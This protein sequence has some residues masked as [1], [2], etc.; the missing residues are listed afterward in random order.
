MLTYAPL[1]QGLEQRLPHGMPQPT[2]RYSHRPIADIRITT[3]QL[4][5]LMTQFHYEA[6]AKFNIDRIVTARVG[7]L[8][9]EEVSVPFEIREHEGQ[10]RVVDVSRRRDIALP[11]PPPPAPLTPP[12]AP[13]ATVPVVALVPPTPTG[14]KASNSA[15]V[16]GAHG[17]PA[18][19][20]ASVAAESVS[21]D[22]GRSRDMAGKRSRW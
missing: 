14:D 4:E 3:D 7:D 22:L 2:R 20:E 19:V 18:R 10:E 17:R 9:V 1:I 21:R 15:A 12:A 6:K 16:C 11:A 13:A 5:D 8:F